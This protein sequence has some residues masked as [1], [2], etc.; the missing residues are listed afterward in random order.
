MFFQRK[1][2]KPM[3]LC[4]Q[5]IETWCVDPSIPLNKHIQQSFHV[6]YFTPESIDKKKIAFW[7]WSNESTESKKLSSSAP[8]FL[9]QTTSYP[10][11]VFTAR[12]K[13]FRLFLHKPPR[14]LL[15]RTFRLT[16]L[17]TWNENGSTCGEAKD[18]LIHFFHFH[19]CFELFIYS[20]SH[21][22]V[23]RLHRHFSSKWKLNQ[24][25]NLNLKNIH[26]ECVLRFN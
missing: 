1:H 17:R 3:F 7:V 5:N 24:I 23:F 22:F 6:F 11:K 19:Y 25:I 15:Q 16:S 20:L 4:Q 10:R 26:F 12:L 9:L 2:S 13:L 8:G 21:F 14:F 18:F